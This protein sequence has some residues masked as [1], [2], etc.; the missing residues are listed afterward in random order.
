MT[1]GLMSWQIILSAADIIVGIILI[2]FEIFVV[3]KGYQKRKAI[4]VKVET[5]EEKLED[6]SQ[7]ALQETAE[8]FQIPAP[9][10]SGY[11]ME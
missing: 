4:P 10:N 2:L 1:T 7:E 6:A 11:A 3:R 8:E 9:L 5:V